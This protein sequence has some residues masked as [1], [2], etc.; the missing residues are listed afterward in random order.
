MHTRVSSRVI[1]R[2]LLVLLALAAVLAAATPT[3]ATPTATIIYVIPGG[4]GGGTSWADGKDLAAALSGAASGSELWVEAGAYKP[5]SGTDRTATFALKDGVAV[6]GGFAGTETSRDQRNP[7][8]NVTTLSGDIGTPN[9][10]SDN[11]YHV[12]TDSGTNNTAILDGF[13]VRAGNANGN[14]FDTVRGGGMLNSGSPTLT[15]V[16]FSGNSASFG[17]GMYNNGGSLTLTNVTFSGNTATGDTAFGGGMFIAGGSLTLTNVTFSGNSASFGGGMYNYQSN[18]ALTNVTFS[19]NS[20]YYAGGGMSNNDSSPTLTNVTFSG[21]SASYDNSTGGGIDN[22]SG[23]PTLTNVTFSGNSA[24]TGGGMYNSSG[25]PTIHN[26]ILWSDTGGEITGSATVTYSI[27]QQATGVYPGTGNLNTDPLFVTPITVSAPT[28]TGNLR[29]Q[30]NSPAINVGNNSD[31]PSGVTTDL[32]GN[33]RIIGASVDMGAYEAL[34]PSDTPAT[35]YVNAAV[36]GGQ[37]DGSSWANASPTLS[38]ALARAQACST[39]TQVWVAKG[40]YK[41]AGPNGDRNATFALRN[42]LAVYGGFTSGQSSLTDRDPNPATN[43]TVLSGDLNGDDGANFANNGDNSY[44]VVTGSG[45]DKTAILDGFTVSGGNANVGDT[46]P[47]ACGG[48]M[49]NANNSSPTLKGVT[50][51]GNSAGGGGGGMF[52]WNNSS[53]TLTNVTFSGNAATGTF[54]DGG[55]MLNLNNSS[56]TLT[57]VTFNS[58]SATGQYGV[59]GGMENANNSSPTLTDVT[60]NSNSA[61]GESGIGLGGGMYN[62][63]SSPTLSHVTFSGNS[64]SYYGGGMYNDNNSSSTLTNVTFS[65]NSVSTDGGGMYN[66]GSSPTLTNVTFSGNSASDAGGG[67][68]NNGSNPTLTNVTFSD[69]SASFFGGGMYNETSSPT[70]TGVTFSGNSAKYA[71]GMANRYE[72]SPTVTDS[73][74]SGNSATHYGGGMVSDHSTPTLT[75]V[76]FSSNSAQLGGGMYNVT[77]SPTLTNVTF[78]GNSASQDGGGLWTDCKDGNQTNMV[79]TNIVF[80]GNSALHG[81]GMFNDG[82]FANPTLVNVTFSGNSATQ[83]GGMYNTLAAIPIVTNSILWGDNGGEIYNDPSSEVPASATVSHSI[84]QGSGGSGTGWQSSVGTDGGGNLDADPLFVAP[85]TTSAPTTTGNLRPQVNSPAINVGSN[86]AIPSGVTTDLDS[87]PRIVF[88]TVDMGAYEAQVAVT[89]FAVSAPSGATQGSPFT[90]TVTAQDPNNATVGGYRGTVHFTSSDTAATLPSDY[91]FTSGD[92]G[93][94]T[95]TS[96]VTLNTLGGQTVTATD[97]ANGSIT[98]SASVNVARPTTTVSSITRVGSTATNATSVSWTVTFANAVSGLTASN[99]A[100]A[101]S[102][103]GGSPTI[104][105]VTPTGSSPATTWTVTASTGTG[106]GSLGLNLVNDTG[107]NDQVTNT[108]FVG[109]VYTIDRTAPTTTI[110]GKPSNPSNSASATFTF[111]ASDGSGSGVASVQCKLDGGAFAPCASSTSQSYSGLADGSH[112][113]TVKATDN[114]GNTETPGASYTWVVDTVAPTT[115][116]T[117]KPTNPSNSAS[118][119]FAFSASDGSGSGVASVQCKLDGASFAPCASST[120]QSYSGLADGSHTFTVKATDNAGNTETP[121]ASYTWTVDTTGPTVSVTSPTN[122]AVYPQGATVT[123]GY[124]CADP[125]GSGVKTCVGTVPNGSAISTAA[126]GAYSFTVNATDNAGNTS[127]VTVAYVVGYTVTPVSPLV[128]PPSVNSLYL[129]GLGPWTTPVKWTLK[130]NAGQAITAAGTVK[131]VTFKGMTCGTTA[132]DPTGA[133][134]A[135]GYSG[136]NPKY[137][138]LQQAW[139]FNWQLP[140]RNACYAL[141]ITLNSSQVIT[142]L[143]NVH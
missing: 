51:N 132:P 9:D 60:F 91:T 92:A 5:T 72:S 50:F 63:G 37:G 122:G 82:Q 26:S 113:F 104:G 114:A 77:S 110:T 79:F 27:V 137:D 100:L 64:T 17:G 10:A 13:T 128:A 96:G 30:V 85:I 83:G 119:T 94:H 58:N 14:T 99:F 33:P 131:S 18:P 3:H 70:L 49:L 120:S 136:T 40:T 66:N 108:P 141:Y 54:G 65:G 101:V 87:K 111:S 139:V 76:T 102:G 55:G 69:N 115:T 57:N 86:A 12:V 109:Q 103:L 48:G 129:T 31:I 46:C 121:G 89:K 84:V 62:S 130:N 25:S 134:T 53:P 11:S 28:T 74:F 2:S 124:T 24:R 107:L 68:L 112:T 4:A 125:G 73:V 140:G 80:S 7:Q 78:S 1:V 143:F 81:G 29:L 16:T 71:G 67:M 35:L 15:N 47:G 142:L 138:A 36:S 75:G 22:E 88:T 105:T 6:Y 21:N 97:K 61:T 127:S 39:V 118:A 98:G 52:N 34:C 106:D 43:G 126:I 56:P 8:T 123:A 45:T 95:F 44:H 20:A 42:N 93:V 38:F 133:A 23:S 90:V 116:I 135:G 41:P 32:D 19:G 59:G 117:G